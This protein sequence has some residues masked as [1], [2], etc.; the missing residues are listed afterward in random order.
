VAIDMQ[1]LDQLASL[2]SGAQGLMKLVSLLA[3]IKGQLMSSEMVIAGI[4]EILMDVFENGKATL[5]GAPFNVAFHVHQLL[6]A[7]YLG[8]GVMVS[9]VGKDHWGDFIRSSVEKSAMSLDYIAV[10]PQ[11]S[12]GTASVIESKGEAG[13]E[14]K[15]DVAWDYICAT[16][17]TDLL[18]TRCSAVAFGSLAQRSATSRH[19]IQQFVSKVKAHRLYDVNLRRNTTNGVAG[20]TDQV[21][22]ESCKLAS[23]VKMNN[24]ELEE[25]SNL[26]GISASQ[27]T[28]EEREWLLM[29]KLCRKYS[30][31]A[32]VITRESQGA[33]LFSGEQRLKLPDSRLPQGAIHPVGGGDAFSAG[34]LVGLIQQWPL[35]SSLELADMMADFVVRHE[36]AT[37]TLTEE[38]RRRLF[39]QALKVP[40]E[41]A[42]Q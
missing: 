30:L 11:H 19:T 5:G 18:A 38:M 37:P 9:R 42:I 14:I 16:P 4:G 8:H 3:S 29:G 10:D 7:P 12:T 13:F 6:M 32:V 35:E 15:Q 17:E 28:S 36:S 2:D 20:Y 1:T 24:Y 33:M 31:H 22:E 39:D 21:I 26:L 40:R 27:P 23:I 41:L 25:V 34:L